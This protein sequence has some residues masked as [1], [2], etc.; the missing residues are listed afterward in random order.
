M[1]PLLGKVSLWVNLTPKKMKHLNPFTRKK[2]GEWFILDLPDLHLWPVRLR[3]I[4]W[5]PACERQLCA[6]KSSFYGYLSALPAP[7][8]WQRF[9]YVCSAALWLLPCLKTTFAPIC[10]CKGR[11]DGAGWDGEPRSAAFAVDTLLPKPP[12][13]FCWDFLSKWILLWGISS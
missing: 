11:A 3:K 12:K 5:A 8:L 1:L 4:F 2:K 7:M 6:G 13:L 9:I 10:C